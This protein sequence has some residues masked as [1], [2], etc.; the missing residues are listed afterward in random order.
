VAERRLYQ[1]YVRS[2]A[3]SNGDGVGDL[4]GVIEKLDY[5]E[6]L[7]VDCVWLSPV[8]PSPDR[9]WGYDVAEYRD[10]QPVVGSLRR[11]RRADR[12]RGRRGLKIVLETG[13][14]GA[15]R[16]RTAPRRT[17]GARRSAEAACG[18][19]I[20]RRARCTSTASSRSRPT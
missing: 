13:T 4:R 12:R 16:I 11:P 9:D 10:V 8:N 5:L 7:G 18:R 6:R 15:T 20:R 2:F 1:V 17:T 3:D 14:S 19:S